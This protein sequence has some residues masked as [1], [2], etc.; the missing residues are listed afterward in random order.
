VLLSGL[1]NLA[2]H[3]AGGQVDGILRVL[4]QA[5]EDGGAFVV[6]VGRADYGSFAGHLF[7]KKCA[8]DNGSWLGGYIGRA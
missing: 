6:V 8:M 7:E 3:E 4:G 2:A 1:G 5:V